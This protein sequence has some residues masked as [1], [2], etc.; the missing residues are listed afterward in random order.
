VRRFPPGSDWLY[1]KLYA[2]TSS[3]DQILASLVAEVV[4]ASAGKFDL[5]FFVRYGDPDWHLRL[6]FHGL[7]DGVNG[8]LRRALEAAASS[9]LGSGRAWRLQHETY[10]RQVERYGGSEGMALSE[11]I[12]HADS[13]TVLA[14]V[15]LVSGGGGSDAR[16]R[17]TLVGIDALLHDLRLDLAAR[18]RV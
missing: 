9:V 10:E 15:P 13:E 8:E 5:W 18:Q 3:L 14:I 7:R 2:G 16:W 12:F 11:R 1:A 6:R 17:L 4:A